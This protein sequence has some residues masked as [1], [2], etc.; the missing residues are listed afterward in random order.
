MN[1]TCTASFDTRSSR[2]LRL[3]PVVAGT[4]QSASAIVAAVARAGTRWRGAA[5]DARDLADNPDEALG[6]DGRR[7][8][9]L[10][11]GGGRSCGAA[12]APGRSRSD[13]RVRSHERQG[14]VAQRICSAVHD[15]FGGARSRA[16]AE[17][18][19]GRRRRPRLHLRDQRHSLG[20]RS[21]ERALLWRTNAP[22]RRQSS[23]P[24]CRP[25]SSTPTSWCISAPTTPAH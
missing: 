20:P 14:A 9:C 6:S 8:A 1:T 13:A 24:P 5:H 18:H 22:R 19:T 10:A 16:G 21:G 4:A 23:A 12:F 15:E 25:S 2:V 7:R 3:P 11:G 17:I